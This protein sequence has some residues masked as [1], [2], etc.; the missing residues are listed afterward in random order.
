MVYVA[1][2]HIF[3]EPKELVN[4]YFFFNFLNLRKLH[5][6]GKKRNLTY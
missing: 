6:K 2:I 3:D 4:I 1:Q 5:D